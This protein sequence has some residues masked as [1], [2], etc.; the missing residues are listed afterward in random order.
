MTTDLIFAR[1]EQ[2]FNAF[3]PPMSN[4]LW[5]AQIVSGT[6]TVFVVPS[7]AQNYVAV[8]SYQQGSD[9]WVSIT[10]TAAGPAGG[11]FAQTGSMLQPAQLHVYAGTEISCYNNGSNNADVGVALY[12]I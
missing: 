4:N 10:G 5:S 7:D 1:D 3:A 11:T 8:F 2:G 12:A 6:S 9:I